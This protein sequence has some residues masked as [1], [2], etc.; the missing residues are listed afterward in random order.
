[1]VFP[2]CLASWTAPPAARR[3]ASS[4]ESS[5]ATLLET[6]AAC[7]AFCWKLAE[8]AGRVIAARGLQRV[9]TERASSLNLPVALMP[10]PTPVRWRYAALVLVEPDLVL[11][12]WPAASVKGRGMD[13]G[14]RSCIVFPDRC[15]AGVGELKVP[16]KSLLG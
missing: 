2:C 3:R 13:T 16:F 8:I 9:I 1:M 10:K 11:A 7:S 4:P 5:E 15:N 14:V 12:V 6:I